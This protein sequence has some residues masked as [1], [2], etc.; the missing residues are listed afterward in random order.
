MKVIDV[1]EGYFAAECTANGRP[2]HA[3]KVCLTATSDA[4]QIT[5]EWLISFFPHDD[6]E[7]FAVSYDA[8][9]SRTV[10][11]GKGRRSKKKEEAFLKDWEAVCDELAAELEGKIFWEQPLREI[12]RG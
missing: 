8:V 7:D 1:L 4:G 5:Y 12:R 11:A 6:D 2:R 9:V 10:F 3:A